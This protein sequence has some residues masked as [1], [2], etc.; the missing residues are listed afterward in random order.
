MTDDVTDNP[1]TPIWFWV[2]AVVFILW[3]LIGVN[4]FYN[5]ATL[6]EAYL[7][8]FPD[9]LEFLKTMPLWAYVAWGIA[10]GG[11]LLGS[12]LFLL[13]RAVAY[14]I[15]IL[16]VI[17]MIISFGYQFTAPNKVEVPAW[18]HVFTAVIW[19]IAFFQVWI[20]RKMTAKGVLR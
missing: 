13:R 6:N 9:M 3:N 2:L 10:T 17:G 8:Q 15:Y 5:S 14:R 11:A 12:V 16:A 20:S 7:A 4:D 18:V 1:K 19:A